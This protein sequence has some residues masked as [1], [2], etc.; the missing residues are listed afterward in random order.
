MRALERGHSLDALVAMHLAD[1]GMERIEPKAFR[2]MLAQGRIAL[3]FDGFDE[4][5]LRITY[6]RAAEHLRTLIEAAAGD[7]HVVVTSRTQHFLSDR[8]VRLAFYEQVERVPNHRIV[9]LDPFDAGRIRQFLVNRLHDDAQAESRLRLLDQVKDLMG[10]SANPRML[11]FIVDLPEADLRQAQSRDGQVTAARLYEL[12]L[13]R[14]LVGEYERMQPRGAAP[15]LSTEDRWQ[16]A[17]DLALCL[18]RKTEATVN[19][20]ELTESV[21]RALTN[22]PALQLHPEQAA[23]Q[24]GSGTLLVR[25]GEGNFSFIHQSVMEWLVAH[26]AAGQLRAEGSDAL[27]TTRPLSPLIADFFSDLAGRERGISWA[28]QTLATSDVSE[29]ARGNARLVLERLGVQLQQGVKL[30]GADLRGQDLSGQQLSY[31]NLTG[32]DL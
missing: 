18:W 2:Y 22:L 25:D 4:L 19:V 9:T 1:A 5:V 3:L 23:Q 15:T 14:W 31:A 20:D 17:T 24:V 12:L 30:A 7:A 6:S 21:S 29:H 28:Q 27:L 26:Q 16:A 11:S 32:A 13:Q 10:L 8:Q